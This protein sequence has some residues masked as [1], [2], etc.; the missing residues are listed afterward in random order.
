MG[1]EGAR[2]P[3]SL[4]RAASLVDVGFSMKNRWR[5]L[6]GWA[7]G[8]MRGAQGARPSPGPLSFQAYSPFQT[9]LPAPPFSRYAPLPAAF[10]PCLRCCWAPLVL[11]GPRPGGRY[12]LH[13]QPREG[14]GPGPRRVSL[15]GLRLFRGSFRSNLLPLS[16]PLVFCPGGQGE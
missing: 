5:G 7:G 3:D 15:S 16:V 8:G 6:R 9:P 10:R 4:P 12:S 1:W 13:G 11:R 2:G 14:Q